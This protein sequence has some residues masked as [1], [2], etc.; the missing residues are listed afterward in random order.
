V[1][2]AGLS[3]EQAAE[4][5]QEEVRDSS[6]SLMVTWKK[7]GMCLPGLLC[8]LM[9]R[10]KCFLDRHNQQLGFASLWWVGLHACSVAKQD[11]A[12]WY[13][14]KVPSTVADTLLISVHTTISSASRHQP[15]T[16]WW[17]VPS[18]WVCEAPPVCHVEHAHDQ[19]PMNTVLHV[20]LEPC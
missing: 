6:S 18:S 19:K 13:H 11:A 9:L 16:S 15:V 20:T 12:W 2:A 7:L 1:T 8:L 10:L 3:D 4:Q 17:M 14:Q 5:D